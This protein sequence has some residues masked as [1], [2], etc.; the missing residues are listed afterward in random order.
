MKKTWIPLVLALVGWVLIACQPA[1]TPQVT[2]K[3][4]AGVEAIASPDL[5]PV[6]AIS[7]NR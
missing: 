6:G 2:T 5:L 3:V 4:Q 1:V 7:S